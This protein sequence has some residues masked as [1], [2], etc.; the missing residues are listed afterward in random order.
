[1]RS[2][3]R[4]NA[5]VLVST[6][7]SVSSYAVSDFREGTGQRGWASNCAR[8]LGIGAIDCGAF[9]GIIMNGKTHTL[10]DLRWP[11]AI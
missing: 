8:R 1:M 2:Q 3:E 6:G 7:P 9:Y 11:A 4:A 5:F 10:G